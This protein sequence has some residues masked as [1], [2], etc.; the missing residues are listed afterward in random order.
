GKRY[1][2]KENKYYCSNCGYETPTTT[3]QEELEK[4][5]KHAPNTG[6][7][8]ISQMKRR[9]R[10]IL[11]ENQGLTEEDLE[12][13]AAAGINPASIRDYFT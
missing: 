6:P 4:K 11:E 2:L 12:D 1:V 3:V 7:L 5:L 9:R 13:L 10:N 8:I